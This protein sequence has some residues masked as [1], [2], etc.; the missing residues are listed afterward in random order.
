MLHF[1]G[2][3]RISFRIGSKGLSSLAFNAF[4]NPSEVLSSQ[5]AADL[6]AP[7]TGEVK[8]AMKSF[9]V[10]TE[11]IFTLKG[12]SFSRTSF[13]VAGSTGVGEI[14]A[15]GAKVS[16]CKASD[17]VFVVSD[18]L[19]SKDA[20]VPHSAVVKIPMLSAAEAA[21]V[22]AAVSAYAILN[23]FKSLQKGDT[24]A[25]LN[26]DSDIGQAISQ[27]GSVKGL[28]VVN[29]TLEALSDPVTFT[30]NNG[31]IKYA[32]SGTSGKPTNALMKTLSPGGALVSYSS[33]AYST[34]EF[35]AVDVPIR[36]FIFSDVSMHG[37]S[38]STFAK[39]ES[40]TFNK[41]VE[42]VVPLIQ[43]KKI[44]LT[45]TVFPMS[46]YSKAITAAEKGTGAVAL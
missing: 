17:S 4:G 39:M 18:G 2:S 3:G 46:Q 40:E 12:I 13:G 35:G 26:S 41:A 5:P 38:L 7:G 16:S 11:D 9:P 31:P 44:K 43:S 37:F 1:G 8:V 27:L 21:M 29:V 45:S 15:V 14:S 32:I 42:E 22:P 30:K 10:V 33:S 28:K 34:E 20:I 19:W 23:K 24:I 25:Q 36:A 6:G